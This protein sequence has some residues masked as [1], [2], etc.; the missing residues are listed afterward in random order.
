[1]FKLKY[2]DFLVRKE[3]RK[4]CRRGTRI[5]SKPLRIDISSM[6]EPKD[7]K[8]KKY[9]MFFQVPNFVKGKCM[10]YTLDIDRIIDR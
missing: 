8:Y 9:N 5:Y 6:I 7:G 1:M 4:L 2:L 3:L 10:R